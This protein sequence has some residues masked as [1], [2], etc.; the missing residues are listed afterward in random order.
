MIVPDHIQDVRGRNARAMARRPQK[1]E[2]AR[3]KRQCQLC[4]VPPEYAALPFNF[5]IFNVAKWTYAA[6]DN[7][8]PDGEKEC[9]VV[10]AEWKLVG[11]IPS[12]WGTIGISY[13]HATSGIWICADG[14]SGKSGYW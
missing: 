6:K 8:C 7:D 1:D 5:D 14:S 10:E 13:G 3:R 9:F 12:P 2:L 11:G 4:M